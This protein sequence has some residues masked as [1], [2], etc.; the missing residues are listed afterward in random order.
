MHLSWSLL[1]K[2]DVLLFCKFTDQV[3]GPKSPP[4]YS[5]QHVSDTGFINYDIHWFYQAR[6]K[7]Y[8]INCRNVSHGSSVKFD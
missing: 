4:D 7:Y 5:I 6:Q 1:E 2:Y 3:G 8:D